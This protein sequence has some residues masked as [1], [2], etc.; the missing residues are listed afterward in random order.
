MGIIS[1][2]NSITILLLPLIVGI[3]APN[4]LPSEWSII[5][6]A[7]AVAIVIGMCVFCCFGDGKPAEWTNI[8]VNQQTIVDETVLAANTNDEANACLARA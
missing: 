2:I 3:L 5:F 7:T 1:I 6:I 4:N 8:D